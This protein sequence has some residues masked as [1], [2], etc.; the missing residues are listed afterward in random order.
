MCGGCMARVLVIGAY[1]LIG[2]AIALRLLAEGHE[3]VGAGRDIAAARQR[4]PALSWI[5]CDLAC[6]RAPEIWLGRLHGIDAV[7]HAA[8]VLQDGAGDDVRAV[9]VDGTGALYAACERAGLRRVIHISAVG[10]DADAGTAFMTTKAEADKSLKQRDLDWA[11]LRPALVIA[12]PAYGGTALLRAL[13]AFPA[14]IPLAARQEAEMQIVSVD[15]V[16]Q[17]VAY[18][19]GDGKT[20]T[21]EWDLAH[22]EIH[23][24]A[25]IAKGFRGWLGLP[26]ATVLHMPGWLSSV[27]A[28]SGDLAGWFGWRNP[29]R[30][31]TLR[32]LEAGVVG[33]PDSWIRD[34]PVA[35][36]D[37]GQALMRHPSAVQDL[38][39]ARL[40]LLKPVIFIALSLFWIVTGLITLGP[41]WETGL[42]LLKGAGIET[43]AE[44]LAVAGALADI[45]LGVTVLFRRTA[46]WALVGMFAVSIG[47]L[48][49]ATLLMPVLWLDPLG[50]L[51]KVFPALVLAGVAA[52]V[53]PSR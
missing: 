43:G 13:A 15:D 44:M 10:A 29:L 48:A 11:I 17:S 27:A 41:G 36:L 3:V 20:L 1:G 6:D 7:V 14:C 32:Q 42:A 39:H 34:F 8:G 33:N 2:Q 40:F 38:W 18:L 31:T 9:Q 24:V 5:A 16:A 53:L 50:P 19:V 37:L 47:Y 21:G 4:F 30:R 25:V 23:D 45:L 46:F 26:S 22:P 51:V 49:A 12:R 35:P 52:A 28:M